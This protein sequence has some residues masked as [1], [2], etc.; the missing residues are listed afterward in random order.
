MIEY[1]ASERINRILAVDRKGELPLIDLAAGQRLG[2]L[3]L[4]AR[5][6]IRVCWLTQVQVAIRHDAATM[7]QE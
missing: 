3:Q 2:R 5:I 6:D 4:K 1:P 7:V